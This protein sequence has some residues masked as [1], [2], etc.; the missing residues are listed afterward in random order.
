M[1]SPP[2]QC[3]LAVNCGW[4]QRAGSMRTQVGE[5]TFQV[6]EMESQVG[7]IGPQVGEIHPQVGEK[8]PQVVEKL[9]YLSCFQQGPFFAVPDHKS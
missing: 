1:S 7:E 6:G 9:F 2:V 3:A 4:M 5:F 8:Y